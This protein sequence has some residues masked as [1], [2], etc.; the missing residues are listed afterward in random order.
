[1]ISCGKYQISSTATIIR[2]A[3]FY[4]NRTAITGEGTAIAAKT[5]C[6]VGL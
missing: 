4:H 3:P 1:V 5:H 2:A 6:L